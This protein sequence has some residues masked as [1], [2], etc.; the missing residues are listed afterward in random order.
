M[1]NL[2]KFIA[3]A[4]IAIL[5]FNSCEDNY[6]EEDAMQALQK[7]D[8][9]VAVTDKSNYD[10]AV[11]GATVS[12]VIDG[13]SVEKTTDATGQVTFED[14]KIGGNL[15]VYVTK[16]D[17]TTTFTTVNTT[18][19]DYRQASVSTSVSIYSLSDESLV[20][21]KGQLTIETDLTN[22][23][24]EVVEGAEVRVY[25][26]YLPNGGAKVFVGISDAEGKYE[27]KVPVNSTG[28][29]YLNVRFH[30]LDT[31]SRTVGVN[32]NN[33][34]SVVTQNAFYDIEG[35]NNP[36]DIPAVPSALITIGAPAALGTGFEISTEIDT[37]T[38]RLTDATGNYWNM[39]MLNAGSGYFPNI[40][41][42]DTTVWVFFSPD[43][44]GL[45]TAR[46]QLTFEKNGGLVSI[47]GM[48]DYGTWNG[49]YAK[50]S[51]K[52]TIDLN[53]GG[54]TGAEIYYNFRLYY[55]ILIS[56]N[57]SGY[58]TLPTVIKTY[59]S[60]GVQSINTYSL[61]SYAFINNGSIYSNTGGKLSMEGRYDS[62]PTFT[63]VVDESAQANAYFIPSWMNSDST[64]DAG[65]YSW[66][67]QGNNYE[68]NNPP[69]VTITSL[70]GYGSGAEFRAEV[71]S[72]GVI[73]NLEL[74]NTGQGYARNINDF[75]SSGTT[76]NYSGDYS[77]YSN[78]NLYN[79]L[80]GDSY[81]VNAYYGTG[82]VIEE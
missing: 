36:T 28:N 2:L 21:V 75:R 67:S 73:N 4:L 66:I 26:Q 35:N 51:A 5:V 46:V 58:I 37:S 23:T 31:V 60:L 61:S 49:R 7:V 1:K 30:S 68:P 76:G 45:D 39:N 27:I 41:G 17:Y 74:I 32:I 70:A 15:N 42:S 48:L 10:Q 12:T 52:P 59:T 62:A 3:F 57:G 53:I 81:T 43:T 50:Y 22:R 9:I 63:I 44:K 65:D 19:S 16:A 6:T 69:T 56:N 14:V 40:T 24:K 77:S 18:P 47:D 64:L 72:T 82:Q 54:G 8:L 13:V 79:V 29:D 25:N 34:Y 11:D 78:S 55:N 38:S 80:P 71:L 20:T 33:H